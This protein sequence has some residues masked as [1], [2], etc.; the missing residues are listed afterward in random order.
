MTQYTSDSAS[1]E[2][3]AGG[4]LLSRRLLL[5]STLFGTG[6][7]A[8]GLTTSTR[9]AAE[10]EI[11]DWVKIS[12]ERAR[13]YGMPAEAEAEVQQAGGGA[14]VGAAGRGGEQATIQLTL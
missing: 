14:A 7:V 4:G 5:K 12:G 11:P 1:L 6:A 9:A 13:G 2:F 8:A 10:A 3:V